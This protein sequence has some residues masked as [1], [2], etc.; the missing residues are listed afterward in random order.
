MYFAPSNPKPWLRAWGLVSDF[1]PP[2]NISLRG[3]AQRYGTV[4]CN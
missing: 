1:I 2:G 3:P 4:N